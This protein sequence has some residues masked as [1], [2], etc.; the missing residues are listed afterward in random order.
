MLMN[1]Q[2]NPSHIVA[3]PEPRIDLSPMATT[4]DEFVLWYAMPG[5]EKV[6]YGVETQEQFA[7]MHGINR[8]TLTRWKNRTDFR[9]RIKELRDEWG[10]SRTSDIIAAIY[11][12]A[13]KGNPLSQ[14]L[15]LQY[16]EDFEEKSQQTHKV[17]HVEIT[18]NDI[19][20]L[21]EALPEPMKTYHY[22][23]LRQLLDDSAA[24]ANA[25]L[26]DEQTLLAHDELEESDRAEGPESGVSGE[27]DN[28]A[29]NVPNLTAYEVAA[30]H[31]RRLCCSVEREVS[32]YHHQGTARRR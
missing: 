21:I 22:A 4:Y 27:A 12:S 15:W 26:I 17:E 10:K 16:F 1:T 19:R 20:F 9:K 2:Q 11:K 18:A 29:P 7:D 32:A 6:K 28:H 13:I 14:K 5:H 30:G 25:R 31:P 23:N 24:H 8:R 3:K